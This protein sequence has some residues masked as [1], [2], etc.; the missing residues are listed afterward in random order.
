MST[1]SD[2]FVTVHIV[3]FIII[4][5][6]V[7]NYFLCPYVCSPICTSF[8]ALGQRFITFFFYFFF[9][10]VQ[11][12][13]KQMVYRPHI[14]FYSFDRWNEWVT[15]TPIFSF[16]RSS[17]LVREIHKGTI[18]T[19]ALH[20]LERMKKTDDDGKEKMSFPFLRRL[21]S[22]NRIL[23]DGRMSSLHWRTS[24]FFFFSLYL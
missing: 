5:P 24:F 13:C 21:C 17:V 23:D 3:C 12:L 11:S 10:W 1:S 22:I 4:F 9:L 6:I 2:T 18:T 7:N 8:D 19:R 20:S 14:M 16:W 15:R